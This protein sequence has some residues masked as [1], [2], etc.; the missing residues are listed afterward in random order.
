M[1]STLPYWTVV[2]ALCALAC[3]NDS[4]LAPAPVDTPVVDPYSGTLLVMTSVFGVAQDP[5]SYVVV[6][7]PGQPDAAPHVLPPH[8]GVARIGNLAPGT[9]DVRLD[10]HIA[11]CE[12]TDHNP[13]SV[14]IESG[15]A[16]LLP[17]AVSCPRP[18]DPMYLRTTPPDP[19]TLDFHAYVAER[20]VLGP[21]G[22]FRFQSVSQVWGQYELVGEITSADSIT[23]LSFSADTRWTATVTF[24]SDCMRVSYN[25]DMAMSDFI[26]GEYCRR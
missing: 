18:A 26:D 11:N 16:T 23:T 20:Y 21:G 25:T 4:G 19:F 1:R 6:V 14:T 5:G 9:H 12:V 3:S 2:S 17:F 22:T 7:G 24:Q 10:S 15:Q 8:G 13:K